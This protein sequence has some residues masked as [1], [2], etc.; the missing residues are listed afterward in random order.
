MY[1]LFIR[2]YVK[3]LLDNLQPIQIQPRRRAKTDAAAAAGNPGEIS[4]LRVLLGLLVD[5]GQRVDGG[6]RHDVIL[7]LQDRLAVPG[8]VHHLVEGVLQDIDLVLL[9]EYVGG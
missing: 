1:L 8:D 5:L 6:E 9:R 2:S 4:H 3:T 7:E